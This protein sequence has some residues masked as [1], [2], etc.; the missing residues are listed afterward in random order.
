LSVTGSDCFVE[1]PALISD[2][3]PIVLAQAHGFSA[4][5]LE[6][7]DQGADEP[8]GPFEQTLQRKAFY[9]TA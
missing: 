7:V 2:R 5:Q 9:E 8:N 3:E 4:A 1:F 6:T